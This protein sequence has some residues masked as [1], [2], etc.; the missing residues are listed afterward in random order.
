MSAGVIATTECDCPICPLIAYN[1]QVC[2]LQIIFPKNPNACFTT[3]IVKNNEL[4]DD[5]KTAVAK[6]VQHV[7]QRSKPKIGNSVE[8]TFKASTSS[9][10][11]FLNVLRK[12]TRIY[13]ACIH[14]QDVVHDSKDEDPTPTQQSNAPSLD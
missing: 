9:K 5:V 13:D 11:C 10:S 3:D 1:I 12:S 6:L 4:P 14:I 2:N 7:R 8:I